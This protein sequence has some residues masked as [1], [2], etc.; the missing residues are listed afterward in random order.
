MQTVLNV[1]LKKPFNLIT[2]SFTYDS[3]DM[4]RFSSGFTARYFDEVV[5]L[6][7]LHKTT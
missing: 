7:S 3:L 4:I 6:I 1:M 5:C 2:Y